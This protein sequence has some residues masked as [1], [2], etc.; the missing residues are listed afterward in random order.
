MGA[1]GAT[2]TTGPGDRKQESRKSLLQRWEQRAYK[3]QDRAGGMLGLQTQIQGSNWRDY[4]VG[5]SLL[6]PFPD[7]ARSIGWMWNVL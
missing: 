3:P 5:P 4:C 6:L 2:V 1:D 7:T